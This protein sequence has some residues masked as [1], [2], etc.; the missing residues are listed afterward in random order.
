MFLFME[1]TVGRDSSESLP[2]AACGMSLE[3]AHPVF[4][5]IRLGMTKATHDL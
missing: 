4:N 3:V 5:N 1:V 2:K